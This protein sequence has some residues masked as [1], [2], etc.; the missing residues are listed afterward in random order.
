MSSGKGDMKKRG[1]RKPFF[2]RRGVW[3]GAALLFVLIA[4]VRWLLQSDLLMGF[5][6]DQ[7]VRMANEQLA[8]T[9]RIDALEGDLL[10]GVRITGIELLDSD[11]ERVAAIDTVQFAWRPLRLIRRTHELDLLILS[12]VELHAIEQEEG[13]W[14]LQR[15]LPERETPPEEETEPLF[16]KIGHFRLSDLFLEASGPSVPDNRV[17]IRELEWIGSAGFEENEWFATVDTLHFLIDEQRLAG[18]VEVSLSA[19]GRGEEWTLERLALQ[20]GRSLLESSLLVEGNER[21]EGELVLAPLSVLDLKSWSDLPLAR[22]LMI[23]AGVRG[24]GDEFRIRLEAEGRG[25]ERALLEGRLIRRGADGFL[26]GIALKEMNLEIGRLEGPLLT[27]KPSAPSIGHI[28]FTGS[29]DV[30]VSAYQEG[31]FSGELVVS[32]LQYGEQRLDHAGLDLEWSGARLDAGLNLRHREQELFADLAVD[33]IFGEPHWSL[34][35]NGREIRPDR[36]LEDPVW[37]GR[38][39]LTLSAEGKGMNPSGVGYRFEIRLQEFDPVRLLALSEDSSGALATQRGRGTPGSPSEQGNSRSP[40]GSQ[41][42]T[43]ESSVTTG[44]SG[45]FTSQVRATIE[46]EGRSLD[47]ESMILDAYVRLDSSSVNGLPVELHSVLQVR[48]GVLVIPETRLSGPIARAS[49]VSR[50]NLKEW[51]DPEN[52]LEM[53]GETGDLQ[54][55]APVF[56]LD[57]LQA[58]G[59][60]RME[61]AA[62]ERGKT[63]VLRLRGDLRIGPFRWDTLLTAES[64]TGEFGAWLMEEP[65]LTATL[66]I[67]QLSSGQ[68]ALQQTDISA[69]ATIGGQVVTGTAGVQLRQEEEIHLRHSASFRYSEEELE[70]TTT[71]FLFETPDRALNL[72]QPFRLIRR[73][74]VL[75][76]EPFRMESADGTA[77]LGLELPHFGPGRQEFRMEARLLNLGTIQRLFMEE[78]VAEAFISGQLYGRMD[79]NGPAGTGELLFARIRH[80]E[81][82]IDS[83]RILLRLEEGRLES[84]LGAWKEERELVTGRIDLPFELADPQSI[85]EAFFARPVDG[86]LTVHESGLDFWHRLAGGGMN[87]AGQVGFRAVLGGTAGDPLLEGEVTLK[88]GVVSGVPVDSLELQFVYNH[89]LSDVRL[90]GRIHSGGEDVITLES[91]VPLYLD[92]RTF[93]METARPDDEIYAMADVSNLDLAILNEFLDP[94]QMRNLQ[95]TISGYAEMRGTRDNPEPSGQ[96]ELTGGRLTVVPVGITLNG[97]SSL[98]TMDASGFRLESFSARS[99]PGQLDAEGVIHLASEGASPSLEISASARQFTAANTSGMNAIVDLDGRFTGTLRSPQLTGDLRFRSGHVNLQNFGEQAVE[100]V[101][102]EGEEVSADLALYDSLSVEM[103]VEFDRQFFI[104]NSQYLEMEVELAGTVDLV[105]EPGSDLQLFGSI[106]GVQGYATPLGRRFNLEEAV[107]TF[108]GPVGNPELMVRTIY[109][110]PQP[111]DDVT[112]WYIVEGTVEEPEFRFDSDPYLELQDIVSYTLFGRPFYAL[113]SWQQA[114]SGGGQGA[115][116]ADLA[117]DLLLDQFENLASRR[118]GIDVVQVDTNRSGSGTTTTIKTGWYLS[119]RTFFAVLN[120]ISGTSP[121][122]LFQLEYRILENLELLLTQGDDS[123]EG[124]DLRWN[125]D[126]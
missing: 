83:L 111:A 71:D 46:G 41:P 23:R 98:L 19:G 110:P 55:L 95:G 119:G 42:V 18:P 125:Y 12:G 115:T 11:G 70:L 84:S 116:A 124:I 79:E 65:Q 105:K 62:G 39:D 56:G 104:R 22:D 35:V 107:V 103:S 3:A 88:E 85:E 106:E 118:L 90:D 53:E 44:G 49:L 58:P 117:L 108:S 10:R 40:G 73:D 120:E 96:F 113:E 51:R 14:N 82:E 77:W 112:L 63:D 36:I 48:N 2:R 57:S 102:L 122:T 1:E 16:W 24:R 89:E 68:I 126:Y 45:R 38:V 32:Q 33:S 86:Q 30:P 60:F 66:S 43:T 54:P 8:G 81:E 59:T 109:R 78:A 9:L 75:R 121:K 99:G 26:E 6:R 101:Y 94:E 76:M 13:D 91:R 80:A 97:I 29:G 20:T 4:G 28:A 67:N 114:I 7:G 93:R 15:L 87:L 31:G 74:G 61:L 27:G 47:P 5:L 34:G 25:L 37:E 17:V 21:V 123:R 64:V 92:M 100:E 50:I 72:D 69:E 52:H